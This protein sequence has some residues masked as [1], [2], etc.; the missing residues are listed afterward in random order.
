[1]AATTARSS[2]VLTL[3][4][5]T[6][7]AKP[8]GRRGKPFM[9]FVLLLVALLPAC[10]RAAVPDGRAE[11]RVVIEAIVAA[12]V[13]LD[14]ALKQADDSSAAGDDE[15][16]AL[17]LEKNASPAADAA[18]ALAGAARIHTP[19]GESRRGELLEVLRARKAEIPR[20]AAAL[21]G[22][23]VNEKLAAAEAQLA[24]Q[25]RAIHAVEA[26]SDSDV[27]AGDGQVVRP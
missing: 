4:G 3:R 10:S 20:Y 8:T 23:D 15:G 19:W 2:Q 24:L 5:N 12:D 21:R 9:R 22:T 13:K 11:D 26:A 25:R 7:G 1:M 18:I 16:A 6:G 27:A 17:L 14:H